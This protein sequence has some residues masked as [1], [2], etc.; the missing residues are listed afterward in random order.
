MEPFNLAIDIVFAS[1]SL[2]PTVIL[3]GYYRKTLILDYL[4]FSLLFFF[5]FMNLLIVIINTD[6]EVSNPLLEQMITS[7]YCII[8]FLIFIHSFRI[9]WEKIPSLVYYPNLIIFI[10]LLISVELFFSKEAEIVILVN[11]LSHFYRIF[12][13]IFAVYAYTTVEILI[14]DRRVERARKLWILVGLLLIL[15]PI[16]QIGETYSVWGSNDIYSIIEI[17]STAGLL[18]VAFIALKYPEFVLISK[19]QITKALNLYTKVTSFQADQIDE[20]GMKSLVNYL[21]QIP[22][23]LIE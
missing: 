1:V 22:P 10:F 8:W 3:Y 5:A 11:V 14:K 9:K 13:L 19:I 17:I 6:L 16:V 15:Y 12:A 2:V 7:F 18:L 23:E 21:R 20:F 4:I